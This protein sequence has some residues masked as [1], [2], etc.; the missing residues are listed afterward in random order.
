MANIELA[1]WVSE[2]IKSLRAYE[3]EDYDCEIKLH[4][5][6]NPFS[7]SD[8]LTL[9]FS[10]GFKDFKLNRYPDP[11]CRVLKQAITGVTGVPSE[12]LVVGNG[13]DE[14]IQLILQIFCGRGD[15]FAFPDPTFGMYSIIGKGLGLIPHSFPLNENWDFDGDEFL[16]FLTEKN[17]RVVFFSYPNNPTGNCYSASEIKKVIAGFQGIVVLDEAY[18]DF[19]QKSFC[20]EIENNNNL[21]L[22]RS[23]SKIG[24]AALR[25]GYGMADPFIIQQINKVRL[26]Y[27]SNT[28]SQEISARVLQNFS[29]IENQIRLI[30]LER[31]RL[32]SE[33]SKF[34]FLTVFPSN[35]NFILFRVAGDGEKLFKKLV[36][37]GVLIRNLNAHPRLKNCLRVTVGTQKEN[38]IF[39][40]QL[41]KIE[42]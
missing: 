24:L 18:F 21:I 11:D 33:L 10:D 1:K 25:V 14:L 38:D 31:D 23:L 27:N 39:L 17:A 36:E 3:V 30:L 29:P 26:P 41:G 19:A 35:S 22:L 8:E 2:N 42:L 6:E 12:N 20:G 34:G 4:A 9:G 40:A 37:N 5:N 32:L 13:S 15:S 7:I 28:F 16:E